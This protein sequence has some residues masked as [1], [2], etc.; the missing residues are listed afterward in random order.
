MIKNAR[1]RLKK[2]ENRISLIFFIITMAIAVAPLISRYC[3]CGHDLEYHL[4]RIESLKEGILIGKPFLKVNTLF[5]G[6]AGYASSMFYSDMYLLIPALLRV[7]GFS[8][9]T[10][11]HIFAIM[12]FVACYLTTYYSVFKMC[13]SKFAASVAAVLLTLCP[14]HMDDILVRGAVGEY[15]AFIFLPLAVYGVYN[16][17][18]EEMDRPAAF[19]VGFAGLILTHPA[20]CI[21]CVFFAFAA[22]IVY[23]KRL[24]KNPSLIIKLALVTIFT[25]LITSF[26][27][28]PMLEQ[29]ASAK[30]YVS[31]NWSDL[32]D[33]SLDLYKVFT[34]DF[35]GL[36]IVL[37][38]L[39]L[40][41][42]TLRRKD[43]PILSFVDFL[44]VMSLVFVIGTTN[45]VM[46]EKIGRFFSFLQFPWRMLIM[47]S[48]LL[49]MAD[50]IIIM[51]F[52]ERFSEIKRELIFDAAL[53]VVVA[54]CAQISINRF[55]E[56]SQGYYDYSD[57]YYSFAPYTGTVIAGEWLPLSVMD[58]QRL[59]EQSTVMTFDDGERCDFT[60]ERATV[61]A[62]IDTA[63]EYA[64]VPFLYYKGYKAYITD[65]SG[66]KT[67]LY[68]TGEGDN[69]ICRV[70]LSGQT[71]KLEVMYK[72]TVLQI[73]S[74]I[75][76]AV[77]LAMILLLWYSGEHNKRRLKINAEKAGAVIS[78]M[79]ILIVVPVAALFLTGC[80]A[81]NI[82]N[83]GEGESEEL[84][85]NPEDMVDYL[86]S[87]NNEREML[88]TEKKEEEEKAL[89]HYNICRSGYEPEGEGFAIKIDESTGDRIISI[90]NQ[91]E[92]K[93]AGAEGYFETDGLYETLLSDGLEA[94]ENAKTDENLRIMNEADMLLC[95]EVYPNNSKSKDIKKVAKE[96]AEDLLKDATKAKKSA[97]DMYMNAAVLT[98]AAYVLEDW[99]DK[100]VAT[101]TA[102]DLFEEAES[103]LKDE[104]EL[105][106]ARVFA[107]AE[108]YRLT[109]MITYKSV[110]DASALEVVPEGFS[111][112]SP[113][114]YGIYTYL[115]SENQGTFTVSSSMMENIF[116]KANAVVK[117]DFKQ[118]IIQKEDARN[119]L[120]NARVVA[121]A[122]YV[123][124]CV[125]YE[126]YMKKA[127][128]YLGGANISG[129][130][131]REK[132]ESLYGEPLY[133]IYDSLI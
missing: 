44:L 43:Y 55:N 67:K 95:L 78:A 34:N 103:N 126:N 65:A 81:V 92:V 110:V 11:Y 27:W 71:G 19:A 16:I 94:I 131:Y 21:L 77:T 26:F 53:I 80:V 88:E 125:E 129:T 89:I 84:F 130:D 32:L 31:Q 12:V 51:I 25:A 35:P 105:S 41:R 73:I 128:C 99:K 46:W 28:L 62:D 120:D 115:I 14:Y 117:D 29:F 69:G 57:D 107:A 124:E 6:G 37:A 93:E 68:V 111:Y 101:D 38:I 18:F 109:G 82:Q 87:R 112:E 45:L 100:D 132:G 61:I 58:S 104:V 60:R 121:L 91:E 1:R 3:I 63:H 74:Y 119:I 116:D 33:A 47:S 96:C 106:G 83:V 113:G 72:S 24:L 20:T 76:S 13:Y 8:I 114:Y 48:T 108:L 54:L 49:A 123:S 133:L 4:L 86:R 85:S 70:Y 39:V 7:M 42:F 9:K 10:S 90:C 59:I 15:M 36:G 40:P 2:R 66:E 52:L 79:S 122:D 17:L 127:L 56:N 23:I 22:F 50:A 97:L 64:E 118:Q 98:K 30:F 75:V 5:F 102:K